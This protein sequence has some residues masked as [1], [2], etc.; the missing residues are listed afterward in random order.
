MSKRLLRLFPNDIPD[1]IPQLIGRE[2]NVVQ[3]DGRTLF[4]TLESSDGTSLLLRDLRSHPHEVRL[5]E[6]AEVV[7]DQKAKAGPNADE[8][9]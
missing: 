6:I 4:G 3:R 5:A 9:H 2:I 7:Y 1:T 8:T